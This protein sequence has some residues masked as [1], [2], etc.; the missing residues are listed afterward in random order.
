MTTLQRLHEGGSP[1]RPAL[2]FLHGLGGDPIDTWRHASCAADDF[3]PLWVGRDTRCDVWT[4]GYAAALSAWTR[5]AMPLPDLG[6]QVLDRLAG[7]GGLNGKPLVL[8]GHSMGGLVIKTAIVHAQSKGNPRWHSLAGQVRAVVFVA[9]PHTGSQL[10]SLAS[11]A[12]LLGRSS[13]QLGDMAAHDAHLRTLQHQFQLATGQLGFATRTYA[14]SRRIEIGRR[15]LGVFIGRRVQVVDRTSA[16]HGRAGDTTI[17]LDEDHFSICKPADRKRQ[18]H[19]SLCDFV[20]HLPAA[21]ALGAG[22]AD[23]R[24][25]Y[26]SAAATAEV[27]EAVSAPPGAQRESGR[28]TSPADSRLQPREPGLYGRATEVAKVLAFLRGDQAAAVAS[29]QVSGVSGIGKTE[30]CKSALKAWLAERPEAVAFYI[31]IPDR[32]SA[33]ELVDRIGRALG[34]DGV[35]TLAHLLA[36]LPR[37]LYYL[38]NL[39]SVA[40]QPEAQVVLRAL[41]AQPGVRLLVSSRLSLPDALG[42]PILI[43]ALPDVDALQLFRDLWAGADELPHDGELAA[44]VVGQLGGHALGVSLAA[45]LG[46]CYAYETLLRRWSAAGVSLAQA[47]SDGSRLGS[48]PIC[49]RLTA[50]ALAPH[51]GALALW[52]VAALFEGGMSDSLL[53]EVEAAG[54]WAEARPRLVRHHLLTR[55]AALW[56]LL[57]PVARFAL[58]SSVRREAEFDWADCRAPVRALFDG[59]ARAAN[60]TVLTRQSLAAR[61]WLLGHFGALARVMQQE[62]AS[63][64]PDRQWLQ[65]THDALIDQY[66][67]RAALS[68]DLL[69]VLMP[70]LDR[71]ASAARLLGD[72]ETQFDRPEEA[73]G[74]YERA[75]TLFGKEQ[76]DPGLAKTMMALGDLEFRLD[77]HEEA[78]GPYDRALALF[79]KVQ[80]GLGQAKTS[81][82][83]GDLEIRLDR[84]EEA[85]GLYERALALF[86]KEQPGLDQANTLQSLGD[87]EIRLGRPEE[88]HGRYERALALFE[89]AKDGLGQAKTSK[90]LGDLEIRLDRPEEAGEWY[91]RALALFG[92]EQQGLDQANTLQALGDL[93][94]RLGRPEEA[95]GRYD[96]ALTLFGKEQDDPGLAKTLQALGDLEIRLG[97]PEEARGPYERALAI[98]E[99]AK[100]GLGQAKTLKALGDLELRWA[101]ADKARALYERALALFGKEQDDPGQAN[102][103]QALGDLEIRLGRP[104]EA[105]GLYERALALFE[106]AKDGLGQANL[107]KSPGRPGIPAGPPG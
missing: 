87:L 106:K 82:A 5:Q 75:L 95:R 62:L 31:D 104:E 107:L 43:E 69:T 15:V 91:D 86:G 92:K 66:P 67:F 7:E 64:D 48:L 81:K 19:S 53:S 1:D 22:A 83:L 84:P 105:R 76:D 88:A 74:R 32:A 16:E 3:W 78:R 63:A 33:D 10:A 100:D 29:A 24:R 71:P 102:T 85:R 61:R 14:E 13:E 40:E 18:I 73:R 58:D 90:A 36:L 45:R 93:E 80:D 34:A 25:D 68:R 35:D 54:G 60:N 59:V 37:G 94:I 77:R 103:L 98:F 11:A 99:K 41:A 8:I 96:R 72:L 57:P 30:V 6:D 56:Y 49:L 2:V 23:A 44:F 21:G 47:S 46:G 17:V 28:L 12:R 26:A 70:Q 9:T 4:L 79:G 39:E 20:R 52:T 101:V 55:R 97:R 42:R 50:D 65:A 51:E 27:L 89:K 38:D